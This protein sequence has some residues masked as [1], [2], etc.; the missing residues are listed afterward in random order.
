MASRLPHVIEHRSAACEGV[1]LMVRSL[2]RLTSRGDGKL[3]CY[4]RFDTKVGF[5][6]VTCLITHHIDANV[7]FLEDG[8]L[9]SALSKSGSQELAAVKSALEE[10]DARQFNVLVRDAGEVAVLVALFREF[11]LALVQRYFCVHDNPFRRGK[12]KKAQQKRLS[13]VGL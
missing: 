5:S 8:L 2:L 3:N 10:L 13:F 7:A 9:K 4:A 1:A 6:R 11:A 12:T